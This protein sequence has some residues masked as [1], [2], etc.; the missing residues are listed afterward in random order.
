MESAFK[1][2]DLTAEQE[3]I[4]LESAMERYR[5]EREARADSLFDE[6]VSFN[7]SG[8]QK[9]FIGESSE[10]KDFCKECYKEECEDLI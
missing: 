1:H 6:W 10:F 8:L 9:D 4:M 3:D 5:E 7:I 2:Q